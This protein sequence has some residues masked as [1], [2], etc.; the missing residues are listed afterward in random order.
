MAQSMSSLLGVKGYVIS[1]WSTKKDLA[2]KF[3]QFINQP[4]YAKIRFE[5]TSEIP[6]LKSVMNDPIITKNEAAN[7]VAIQSTRAVPMPSIPEMAQVWT[8]IDAAL[9]LSVSGKQ[10]AKDALEGAAQ[11]INDSIEAFRSGY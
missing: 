10:D 3:I 11:Q 7:A 8:P 9:Q 4:Q 6:P 5:Q 1:S 2:E